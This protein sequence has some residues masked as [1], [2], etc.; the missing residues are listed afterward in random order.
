MLDSIIDPF[1]TATDQKSFLNFE[2]F[3]EVDLGRD[4]SGI[5]LNTFSLHGKSMIQ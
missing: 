2:E 1:G 3:F 5:T 4:E